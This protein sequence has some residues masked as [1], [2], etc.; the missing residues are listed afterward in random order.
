MLTEEEMLSLL[1]AVSGLLDSMPRRT[2]RE[3]GLLWEIEDIITRLEK[4]TTD[5]T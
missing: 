4:E 1:R 5:E 3:T 2:D